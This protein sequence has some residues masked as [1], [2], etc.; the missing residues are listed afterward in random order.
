MRRRSK[1]IIVSAIVVVAALLTPIIGPFTF[2]EAVVPIVG[3]VLPRPDG[4]PNAASASYSWK[5]FG[6][7]W[8]WD[9]A[10]P[11]GCAKWGAADG[12][13]Y[14]DVRLVTG[15]EGC[16]SVGLPLQHASHSDHI[17]FGEGGDWVGGEPCAFTVSREQIAAFERLLHQA[18]EVATPDIELRALRRIELRL[19][20]VN[21]SALTTDHTGGC[22]DLKVADFGKS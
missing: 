15:L 13:D 3:P 21:G 7:F 9:Q 8:K 17:V 12:Q 5:G 16:D 22:N 1:I 4:V 14:Y 11:N 20:S 19:G 6:L 18:K 10:L 2:Y